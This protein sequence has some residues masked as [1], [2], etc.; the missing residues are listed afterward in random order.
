MRKVGFIAIYKANLMMDSSL[1]KLKIKVF[2]WS[3]NTL[4]HSQQMYFRTI[5]LLIYIYHCYDISPSYKAEK[6]K[7]TWKELIFYVLAKTR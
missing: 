4:S 1:R 5:L 2:V 6:E 7:R 3:L